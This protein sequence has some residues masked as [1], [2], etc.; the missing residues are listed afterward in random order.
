M[1]HHQAGAELEERLAVSID[2]LIQNGPPC[3]IND[4]SVQLVHNVASV[5]SCETGLTIGK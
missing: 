1:L 4:S 5:A 2:K 3:G